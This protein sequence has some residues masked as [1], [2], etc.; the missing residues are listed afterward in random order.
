MV[1][2]KICG[3]SSDDALDAAVSHGAS[4]VGFVHHAPSPRHV[5]LA[6]AAALRA[7]LPSHVQAV[8][9]LVNASPEE[10][11]AA[12]AAVRPD[13][14]QFHG[15]ETPDWLRLVRQLTGVEVWKALGI[16]NSAALDASDRFI[17]SASRLLFDAPA[18]ALPGGNGV[19]IDWS[20]LAGHRHRLPWGLAGGLTA[21]NLPEAVR[22]TGAPLVDT[23][24]GVESAPGVKDMSMIADFLRAARDL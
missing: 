11:Q 9:L 23:S 15:G 24:S 13:V 6:R 19:R 8:L 14:V 18:G 21:G 16:R 12:I 3:I 4:H 17:G 1:L 7:R 5:P 20:I 2:A 22:V 10:T